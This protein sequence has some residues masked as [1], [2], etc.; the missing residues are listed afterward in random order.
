VARRGVLFESR[1][2]PSGSRYRVIG[3]L[4]LNGDGEAEPGSEEAEP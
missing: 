2:S 4:P 1:L 3:E